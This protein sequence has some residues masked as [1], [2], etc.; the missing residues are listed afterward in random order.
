[1]TEVIVV[2]IIIA[3]INYYIEKELDFPGRSDGEESTC[4]EGDSG[5]V[6]GSWIWEIL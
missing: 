1:M 3:I 5:M 4:S 2:I 6:P